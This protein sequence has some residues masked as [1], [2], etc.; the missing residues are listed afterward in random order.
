MICK[1]FQDFTKDFSLELNQSEWRTIIAYD[2]CDTV[3]KFLP[4][5]HIE[6]LLV[7]LKYL[8]L[9]PIFETLSATFKGTLKI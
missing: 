1:T 7:R 3:I 4:S 2:F 6:N 8:I 9:K 5:D